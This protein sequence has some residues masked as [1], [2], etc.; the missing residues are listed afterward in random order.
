[1]TRRWTMGLALLAACAAGAAEYANT[2]D[3]LG[4]GPVE[5]RCAEA[6]GWTFAVTCAAGA[7]G[8]PEAKLRH[9]F[10]LTTQMALCELETKTLLKKFDEVG[11][12]ADSA[13]VSSTD[14]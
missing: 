7:D 4:V 13:E 8:V 12:V 1:M 5:V 14:I 6:G 11:R 2:I 10:R 9:P 3:G